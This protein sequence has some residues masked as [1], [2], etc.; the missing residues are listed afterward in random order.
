MA[1]EAFQHRQRR[2]QVSTGKPLWRGSFDD[3]LR[4]FHEEG[5]DIAALQ[6]LLDRARY[7]PV[8]TAHPTEARR[9]TVMEC[10]RRIF[11][12]GQELD[13]TQLS[14]YQKREIEA[15]LE[16]NIQILWET[17]EIRH[18]RLTVEA[19][20]KNGLYYFRNAIFPAV[21]EVYRNME[22]AILRNYADEGGN[23]AIRV[24]SFLRFGSWIGGDRDGNPFVTPQVTRTALRLQHREILAEYLR[25][26]QDLMK[27]LTQSDTIA[28]TPAL[29]ELFL[30]QEKLIARA[31][32]RDDPDR[33]QHE[34]YR[35]KLAIMAFRLAQNIEHV[36]Q[37][38]QGFETLRLGHAYASEQD[39]LHDL[40]RLREALKAHGDGNLTTGR[41]KDLIRLAETFGFFLAQLDL[42][43]ESARHT[44]AV[45]QVL[46][47]AGI[48]AEYTRLDE[49]A[50]TKLLGQLIA[51]A[52][53][54]DFSEADLS[55]EARDVLDVFYLMHEMRQ[56][57]SPECFGNYVISMTH[58]ASHVME[59]LF[60]ARLAELVER[61]A[62]GRWRCD[63]RISPLFETIED[64]ERI[65]DVLG[66]LLR[67]P[68]YSGA[69]AASGNLQEVM[70]G[71]SDSA[72]DGGILASAWNLYKAQQKVIELT[73]R[74]GVQ[75]RLFH[76]R[77]GTV[78]RGGGPTHDSILAQPPGTV[79]GQ[80]KITEQGEVLTYKYGNYETAVYELTMGAS[81]LLKAS[82][83]TVKEVPQ[84][85]PAEFRNLMDR[86]ARWGEAH[87][88]DLTERTPGL[89]DYFYEATPVQEIAQMNIGSRPSHRKKTDRS[90]AS[91]RAI[92]WVFGWA[93][94][95]H[96]LPAW[97]GIGHAL[98]RYQQEEES[99]FERLRRMYEAWPFFR[100][101]LDT[102]QMAL[103]KADMGIA[104]LYARLAHDQQQAQVIYAK[105]AREFQR[106]MEQV[107]RVCDIAELIEENP[108]LQ[109]S[110]Q[111][112]N[113]YLDPLNHIQ[114]VLLERHRRER[115][116]DSG[117][118]RYLRPLL[119][120]INAIAAGMRNTG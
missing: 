80:I 104:R 109:F 89:L 93:Q 29:S 15:R 44:E 33:F 52:T 1:E 38:L 2:V 108:V 117:E 21:P 87:Y 51:G 72:K 40:Y 105:V 30:P 23:R 68:V 107:L 77:G 46:A 16:A 103:F 7:I 58:A 98:E 63:I 13:N 6:R 31:A 8:F 86:L 70:L 19:E 18:R 5:V 90:K 17:E 53:A 75:C 64:L 57:I 34:P 50:R 45:A 114:V 54:P 35:R 116:P 65:E 42:R 76:G 115:D 41:L 39:F 60:L 3:T 120:S 22:R 48:E 113:P 26:T 4:M 101:L 97:Y 88:R 14:R 83:H 82:C 56:E 27:I 74:Y 92:P 84:S 67:H 12:I 61:D 11:L 79:N 118:S 62:Q 36:E 119:R 69:L 85:E 32:F 55:P 71:Y 37:R 94:S 100:A 81:G 110:L 59:V 78:G 73:A 10:L 96:T 66:T 24:P 106:T 91:I 95:R 25:R 20:V 111:R 28:D 112:R 102:T 43:Q 9:R 49:A 47:S 99:G